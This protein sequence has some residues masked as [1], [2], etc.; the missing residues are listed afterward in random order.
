MLPPKD[1]QMNDIHC[2]YLWYLF[3]ALENDEEP[4]KRGSSPLPI[5]PDCKITFF[6]GEHIGVNWAIFLLAV[7]SAKIH[8]FMIIPV[9]MGQSG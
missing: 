3:C 9:H 2:S 1:D 8:C 4:T 7:A 6:G 5:I